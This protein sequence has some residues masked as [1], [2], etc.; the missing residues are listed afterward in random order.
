MQPLLVLEPI[1]G[2][3][4]DMFLAAALDLGVDRATP[5]G[6]APHARRAGLAARRSRAE[7]QSA[8]LGTHVDVVVEG[9]GAPRALPRRD[10]RARRRERARA[11]REGR[12]ARAVRADRPGGGEGPRHP[13]RGGALPRGRRGGLDRGRL[14]R[15]GGARPARLAARRLRAA[16]ARPRDRAH[17]AR[18][19][20][21]PAARRA[22]APRRYAGAPG[23]P[24]RRGGHA[25][26]RG[27]P[28]RARRGSA[29]CRRSCHAGSA[30]ASARSPGP[31]GRTCCG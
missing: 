6:R 17:R 18:P 31:T 24:A 7:A 4:G 13:D 2:I 16:R 19:G 3:A 25:H 11:A 10:P 28:R 8:I 15:G 26:R 9:A 29:R 20:A 14:R 30:T 1:G 21:D 27:D 22:R 12:R 23:R 5:R